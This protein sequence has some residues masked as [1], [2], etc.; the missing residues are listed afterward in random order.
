MLLETLA[1]SGLYDLVRF[2]GKLF[3]GKFCTDFKKAKKYAA[4]EVVEKYPEIF[5]TVNFADYI[6]KLE[7]Q[8]VKA[9]LEKLNKGI[10]T[11]DENLLITAVEKDLSEQFPGAKGKIKE[12]VSYFKK[13]MTEKLQENHEILNYFSHK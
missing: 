7:D 11:I 4:A 10:E 13:C 8:E 1:L 9:E 6:F 5:P 3:V 12:V 2:S